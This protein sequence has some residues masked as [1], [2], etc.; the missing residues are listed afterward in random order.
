MF[1]YNK[2][3]ISL[4]CKTTLSG[5]K[6]S[7]PS[8]FHRRALISVITLFCNKKFRQFWSTELR[9]GRRPADSVILWELK[10]PL[11]NYLFYFVIYLF[12]LWRFH[13]GARYFHRVT[14]LAV[15]W[16]ITSFFM[17]AC[18]LASSFWWKMSKKFHI[19]VVQWLDIFH[20]FTQLN[21]YGWTSSLGLKSELG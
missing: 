18:F 16:L 3:N 20:G 13:V 14:A 9:G 8:N 6:T 4:S 17:R 15:F 7:F 1:I 5:H 10:Y 11:L 12:I 2:N 19:T 21:F